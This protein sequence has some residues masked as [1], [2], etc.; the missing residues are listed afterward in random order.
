MMAPVHDPG[1]GRAFAQASAALLRAAA[2]QS[3]E[4]PVQRLLTDGVTA[5]LLCALVNLALWLARAVYPGG[6]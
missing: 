4:L 2:A 5:A 1:A 6:R 3:L